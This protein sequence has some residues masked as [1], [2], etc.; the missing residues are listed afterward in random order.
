M[1]QLYYL[2]ELF[3]SSTNSISAPKTMEQCG[4]KPALKYLNELNE[5]NIL[6]LFK[7][8]KVL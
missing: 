7:K 5:N 3:A 6:F 2:L 8:K 1:E 4:L